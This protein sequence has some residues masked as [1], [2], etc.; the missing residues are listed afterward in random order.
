MIFLFA[1]SITGGR[2]KVNIDRIPELST[3]YQAKILRVDSVLQIIALFEY[4]RLCSVWCVT[5]AISNHLS[6]LEYL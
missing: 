5:V 1:S 4:A 3:I 6:Y 2:Y